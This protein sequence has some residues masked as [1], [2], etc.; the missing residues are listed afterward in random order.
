MAPQKK[1]TVIIADDHTLVRRG[2]VTLL[3]LNKD[4]DVIAEVGDGRIAIEITLEKK[5]DVVMMDL[6]M[7]NLSGFEA[8]RQIKRRAPGVKILVLSAYDNEEYVLETIQSGADGYMLKDTTPGEL[9]MALKT[10]SA[11]KTYY[12][13][14]IA[15]FAHE[16]KTTAASS[17]SGKALK[18]ADRLTEREREILQLIAE[19]R[20]HQQIAE[21]LHISVRTVDTHRNNIIQKLGLHDTASLV[22]FAIKN[23]IVILSR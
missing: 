17:L 23:G 3:S 11:G 4:V 8:I 6:S 16:V 18:I 12:S 19:S 7:P 21:M 15:A 22:T 13:P 5:P 14:S 1:I 10:V 2:L 20:T 9:N